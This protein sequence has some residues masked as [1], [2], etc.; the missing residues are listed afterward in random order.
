[1]K[2]NLQKLLQ[3]NIFMSV[4]ATSI[5]ITSIL[6][7]VMAYESFF[8]WSVHMT[9]FLQKV[10]KKE[11]PKG[12]IDS[13]VVQL[14]KFEDQKMHVEMF[15]YRSWIMRFLKPNA[16]F[17]RLHWSYKEQPLFYGRKKPSAILQ[18]SPRNISLL[19]LG[20]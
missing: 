5:L 8:S 6:K 3:S 15:M 4:Q 9:L 20:N 16:S 17:T 1:M 11:L 13:K 10:S 19:R 7:F 12:L 2:P 14:F 18:K